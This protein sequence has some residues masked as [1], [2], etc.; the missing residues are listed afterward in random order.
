MA[1][2]EATKVYPKTIEAN[3]EEMKSVSVHLEVAMEETTVETFRAM[4]RRYSDWHLAV[5]RRG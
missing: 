3:P 1:C 2:Q 5:R 4:K